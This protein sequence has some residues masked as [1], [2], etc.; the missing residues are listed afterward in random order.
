[1]AV[2]RYGDFESLR[3]R[4]PRHPRLRGDASRH[5]A[6]DVRSQRATRA[7]ARCIGRAMPPKTRGRP[8][9]RILR[10]TR[11]EDR[12]QGQVHGD[13]GDRAQSVPR[14]QR[15]HAGRNRS[16]RIH[17]PA[18][19]RTAEPHHRAGVS[20]LARNRW[21]RPFATRTPNSIRKRS[22]DERNALVQEAR[23]ML[24]R[25]FEG[26]DAGITGANFLLG[27]RRRGDHRH[28]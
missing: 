23:A 25:Q 1:M 8:C 13:R 12:H 28:Q 22:L 6:R 5:A 26:A 20:P 15:H 10:E 21:R 18:S 3:D 4:G 14:S 2:Q 16:R 7:A 24:R 27:R 17:H 9:S 19:P 11:R